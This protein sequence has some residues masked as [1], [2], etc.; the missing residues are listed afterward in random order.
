[1]LQC[2]FAGDAG[3]AAR[4]LDANNRGARDMTYPDGGLK[5]DNDKWKIVQ[6]G[7]MNQAVAAKFED[8]TLRAKLAGTHPCRLLEGPP[9]PGMSTTL[10]RALMHVRDTI[11]KE[12]A[13][14]ARP[15]PN[16]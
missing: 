14:A 12:R 15:P 11:V 1:M 13:H 6:Q 10:T 16:K 5:L 9:K 8:P 7:I 2:M 4:V 3:R